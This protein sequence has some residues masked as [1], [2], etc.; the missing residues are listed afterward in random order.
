MYCFC[1][2]ATATVS[3]MKSLSKFVLYK[4]VY[5]FLLSKPYFDFYYVLSSDKEKENTLNQKSKFPSDIFWY[6]KLVKC[7][8]QFFQLFI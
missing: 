5:S 3:I 7:L 6:N 2:D 8:I 4:D 1:P